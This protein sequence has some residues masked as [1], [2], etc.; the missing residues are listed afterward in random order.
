MART[1]AKF[2]GVAEV[3]QLEPT[4]KSDLVGA[5]P[6]VAVEVSEKLTTDPVDA[7]H[8]D[9]TLT[10]WAAGEVTIKDNSGESPCGSLTTA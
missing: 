3:L 4:R 7:V 1:V 9:H 8:I 6:I 10:D 5:L 2:E